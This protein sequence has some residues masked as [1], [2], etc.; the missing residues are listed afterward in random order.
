M[1]KWE[2]AEGTQSQGVDEQ[3]SWQIDV[4]KWGNNPSNISV[5]AYIN[6]SDITD[7]VFPTNSP[8]ATNNIITLSPLCNLSM[9]VTYRIEVSFT[10][11]D[12]SQWE[13]F[14]K[15]ACEH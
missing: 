9:G 6:N 2:V 3:L 15:V 8:S 7:L 11:D 14:F 4:S 13:C 5:V 10:T 1:A 12:S